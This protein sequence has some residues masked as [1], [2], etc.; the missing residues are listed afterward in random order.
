MKLKPC[1]FC[2]SERL[3]ILITYCNHWWYGYVSCVHCDARG[4][5]CY[6]KRTK[7][8]AKTYSI[9]LWNERKV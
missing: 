5:E 3:E 7:K 8:E 2:E 6:S 1:P 9:K 4:P